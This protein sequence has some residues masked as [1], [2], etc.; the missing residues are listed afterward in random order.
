MMM[1]MMMMMMMLTGNSGGP[2]TSGAAADW[3]VH[4]PECRAR[5]AGQ[6]LTRRMRR[7][8]AFFFFSHNDVR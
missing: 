6:T 5:S 4:P 8:A 1:M 2:V 3:P 7:F